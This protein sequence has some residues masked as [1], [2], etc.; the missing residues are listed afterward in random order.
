MK[1]V[2]VNELSVVSVVEMENIFMD[3]FS[4]DIDSND[5]VIEVMVGCRGIVDEIKKVDVVDDMFVVKSEDEI[6][7]VILSDFD[8][9]ELDEEDDVEECKEELCEFVF[10]D[11]DEIEGKKMYVEGWYEESVSY[12]VRVK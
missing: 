7:E 10:S 6:K 4:N 12:F 11:I 2:N 1:K 3:D 8:V 9:E 5:V